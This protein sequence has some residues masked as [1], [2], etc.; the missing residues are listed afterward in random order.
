MRLSVSRVW[1]CCIH[2]N[3]KCWESCWSFETHV[4]SILTCLWIIPRLRCRWFFSFSLF[5]R[6]W[7]YSFFLCCGRSARTMQAQHLA[8]KQREAFWLA[9]LFFLQPLLVLSLRGRLRHRWCAHT[10]RTSSIQHNFQFLFQLSSYT[11]NVEYMLRL[12]GFSCLSHAKTQN[13]FEK[14]SF[15]VPTTHS[16]EQ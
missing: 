7:C 15:F 1:S 13:L 6:V 4:H 3:W 2:E 14:N 10:L 12:Y 8:P 16:K 9:T 11:T 5:I